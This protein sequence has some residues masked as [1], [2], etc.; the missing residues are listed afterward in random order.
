M[1]AQGFPPGSFHLKAVRIWDSS[2]FDLFKPGTETKPAAIRPILEAFPGRTFVLVGDSG[3]KDPEIYGELL[4][5]HPPQRIRHAYIRNLTGQA[6]E[7]PRWQTAF[8]EVD[9]SRWTL[10]KNPAEIQ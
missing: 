7:D 3:E 10:F 2:F 6:R 1:A 4:R 9:P 5:Q 8:R